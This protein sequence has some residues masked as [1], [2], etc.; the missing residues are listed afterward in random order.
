VN[1][2]TSL[3]LL[4]LVLA[5][6]GAHASAPAQ[7][8]PASAPKPLE[9]FQ[10]LVW[11]RAARAVDL[12]VRFGDVVAFR[13][14]VPASHAASALDGGAVVQLPAGSYELRVIDHT[15]GAEEKIRVAV[16][17][18]GPHVGVHLTAE[19]FALVLTRQGIHALTP[20]VAA[21]P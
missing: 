2:R 10:L 16:E 11:N 18:G 3:A 13:G 7:P 19:G 20:G 17:R 12:E 15:R 8:D 5:T 14:T 4:M 1:M 6:F 9:T 21:G